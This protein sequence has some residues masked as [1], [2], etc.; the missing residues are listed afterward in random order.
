MMAVHKAI[1][2][3]PPAQ[4]QRQNHQLKAE[5]FDAFQRLNRGFGIA[6]AALDRLGTNDR[7]QTRNGPRIFPDACLYDYRNRT[8][9]LRADANRDL[10]RLVA[11]Y[12]DQE[13][14]RLDR[15]STRQPKRKSRS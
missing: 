3:N 10:L 12:E 15:S 7:V 5:L 8:E 4:Q 9:M 2:S 6:L 13:A 14:A 11:G 1:R